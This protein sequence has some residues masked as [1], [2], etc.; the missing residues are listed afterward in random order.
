MLKV[1]FHTYRSEATDP[2]GGG[3]GGTAPDKGEKQGEAS[4]PPEKQ[5]GPNWLENA[6]AAARSKGALQKE[7]ATLK[8]RLK[9]I[10]P[11]LK[12]AQ[13]ELK[14]LRADQAQLREAFEG[15]QEEAK[16]VQE[17]VTEELASVGVDVKQAPPVAQTKPKG[18]VEELTERM[19][20]STDPAER[21]KLADQ[22]WEAM[23]KQK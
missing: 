21:F 15:A 19:E 2:D 8:A 17:T 14:Q 13:D 6:M 1:P 18:S 3:S 5:E 16:S 10:E 4:P 20:A 23:A 22:V 12:K 11:Q 7:N 9:E